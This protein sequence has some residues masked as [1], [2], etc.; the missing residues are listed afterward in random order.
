MASGS[1]NQVNWVFVDCER[2]ELRTIMT[3]SIDQV[4]PLI[5]Q[6][7]VP[8]NMPLWNPNEIGDVLVIENKVLSLPKVVQ[9]QVIVYPNPFDTVLNIDLPTILNELVLTMV[10]MQGRVV[11]KETKQVTNGRLTLNTYEIQN[12]IVFLT[13]ATTA[14]KVLVTKKLFKTNNSIVVL[15]FK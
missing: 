8:S 10:D 13:I 11:L 3:D 12:G 6:F 7:D 1:F 14:G 15:R 4:K 5:N 2:I 9:S